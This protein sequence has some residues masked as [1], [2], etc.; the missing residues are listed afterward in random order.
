V[1]R[2]PRERHPRS[3]EVASALALGEDDAL[4]AGW[5]KRRARLDAGDEGETGRRLAP[6]KMSA[7]AKAA[8]QE[9]TF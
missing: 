2:G 4:C 9:S 8:D 5:P 6:P 1:E 7:P 3:R